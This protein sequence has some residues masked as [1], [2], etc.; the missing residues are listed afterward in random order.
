MRGRGNSRR[1]I[2]LAERFPIRSCSCTFSKCVRGNRELF[3]R[4]SNH[5]SLKQRASD[6][7][8][9]RMPTITINGQDMQIGEQDRLNVIQAAERAGVEIPYYCWHPGLS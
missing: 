6:L 8:N 2:A 7:R 3:V 4:R 1:N 9:R 5:W